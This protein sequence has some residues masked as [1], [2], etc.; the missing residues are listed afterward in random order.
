MSNDFNKLD[1][2]NVLIV[3]NIKMYFSFVLWFKM[4]IKLILGFFLKFLIYYLI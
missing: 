1:N 4:F 2:F 3:N